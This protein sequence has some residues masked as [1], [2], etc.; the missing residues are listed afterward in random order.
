M[1]M[2]KILL[3]SVV[4]GGML[5]SVMGCSKS[6]KGNDSAADTDTIEEFMCPCCLIEES[7]MVVTEEP[8]IAVDSVA[9]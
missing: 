7:E 4:M 3:F 8:V 6:G 5:V 9:K 1:R 2:K